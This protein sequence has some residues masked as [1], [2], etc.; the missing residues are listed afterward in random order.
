MAPPPVQVNIT[1]KV[2]NIPLLNGDMENVYQQMELN[3]EEIERSRQRFVDAKAEYDNNCNQLLLL[4]IQQTGE[5][6]PS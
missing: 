4:Y 5:F 3:K 2:Y 1:S 6:P